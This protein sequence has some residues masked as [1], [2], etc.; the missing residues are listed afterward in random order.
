MIFM[1]KKFFPAAILTAALLFNAA[2]NTA[3]AREVYIGTSEATGW[4]CYIITETIERFIQGDVA[5]L[6]MV[7]PDGSAS[8]IRYNFNYDEDADVV[9]F[10]NEAGYSGIVNKYETPIE[11]AM[12]QYIDDNY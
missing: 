10:S 11:W 5:V 3:E 9:R 2:P 8:Y 6:R 1:L 12:Y 4:E 7:K